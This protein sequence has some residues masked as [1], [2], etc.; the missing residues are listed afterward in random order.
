MSFLHLLCVRV[1]HEQFT[2]IFL[3]LGT[4]KLIRFDWGIGRRNSAADSPL[5]YIPISTNTLSSEDSGH[6]LIEV[7]C[8]RASESF[9]Q[10]V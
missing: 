3:L 7:C 6:E 8:I 2:D 1:A 5:I 9:F 10:H 4:L